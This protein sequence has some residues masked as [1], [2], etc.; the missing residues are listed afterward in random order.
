[1]ADWPVGLSTGCFYSRDIMEVLEPIR[2][3]GFGMIEVC[4]FPKHL[5][6]HD[7][8]RVEA[9]AAR[10]RE[11]HLEAYSF[12][13]PFAEHIDLSSPDPMRV[14]ASIREMFIAAE[15][16]S[17]MGARYFVI[18]PGPETGRV[19]SEQYV[20]RMETVARALDII[21]RRCRE[22]GV[23]LVLENKL[24]HLFAGDVRDL[25]WLLGAMQGEGVG[26]CLDTGHAYLS[27][28]LGTVAYKLAGHLWMVHASD[29]KGSFDDHLPPGEGAIDWESLL[30]RL[31]K[32]RFLGALILEMAGE[33]DVDGVLE[34]A[35]RGRS[36]LRRI[37]GKALVY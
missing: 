26:L 34:R 17:L 25:L 6:Y 36:Y 27:G 24:P 10:I 29:N 11:L 3:A 37:I 16:A 9:A 19:P 4:S 14:E 33:D 28:Y 13:A 8:G 7:R 18:H 30:A 12:H 1:M 15:A 35:Q 5:D 21:S 31:S 22:L 32:T 20:A 2:K 23:G